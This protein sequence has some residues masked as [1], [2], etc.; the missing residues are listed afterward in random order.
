MNRTISSALISGVATLVFAITAIA[1]DDHKWNFNA[2][3]GYTPVAGSTDN[4][5]DGGGNLSIGAGYNFG[6]SVF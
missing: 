4:H 1:Q 5:L 2:G 6:N 3:G